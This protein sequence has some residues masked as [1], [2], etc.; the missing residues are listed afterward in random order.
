MQP[1]VHVHYLA[2]SVHSRISDKVSK[3]PNGRE[4][5][6]MVSSELQ[7]NTANAVTP[8]FAWADEIKVDINLQVNASY[9]DRL[10]QSMRRAAE[11]C[12]GYPP[13]PAASWRERLRQLALS[14]PVT[15]KDSARGEQVLQRERISIPCTLSARW[16]PGGVEEGGG[17]CT[18]FSANSQRPGPRRAMMIA[19]E[20]C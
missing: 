15:P 1:R 5:I 14:H 12:R 18:V 13:R 10:I 19:S 7:V 2:N 6:V 9:C 16:W 20:S 17:G 11:R 4:V 8:Q 3:F